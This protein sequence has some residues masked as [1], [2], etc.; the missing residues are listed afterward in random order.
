MNPP[1]EAP[2]MCECEKGWCDCVHIPLIVESETTEDREF[3]EG[4][5][6]DRERESHD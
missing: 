5:I 3:Y 2:K 4:M 6:E 1:E